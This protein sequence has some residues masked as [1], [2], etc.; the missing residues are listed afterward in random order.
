MYH[1]LCLVLCDVTRDPYVF[2][3]TSSNVSTLQQGKYD[4]A[5]RKSWIPVARHFV[6][7]RKITF[8]KEE[9][10]IKFLFSN[11][12]RQKSLMKNSESR[13]E[14]ISSSGISCVIQSEKPESLF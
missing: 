4:K 7:T 13:E 14:W 1:F 8:S 6:L 12:N 5:L 10:K 3:K 2:Y 9:R 11:S